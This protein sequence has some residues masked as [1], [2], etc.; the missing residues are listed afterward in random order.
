MRSSRPVFKGLAGT[1][2]GL[3]SA[4]EDIFDAILLMQREERRDIALKG[5]VGLDGDEAA[6]GAETLLLSGDD[7]EV[8]RVQF[9]DDH[10]DIFGVAMCA[11]VGDDGDVGFRV[12]LFESSRRVFGH[13]DSTEDE[14]DHLADL[15]D[16]VFGVHDD[17]VFEFLRH[18]GLDPWRRE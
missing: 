10:R 13:V 17:D 5:A 4:D 7:V 1:G 16:V 2:N 18:R 9:R 15:L 11:V 14:V 12:S 3:V 8:L 6:G